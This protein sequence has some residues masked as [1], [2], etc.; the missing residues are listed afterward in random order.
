MED[1]GE[2]KDEKEKRGEDERGE[3]FP[4]SSR[5]LS[6]KPQADWVAGAHRVRNVSSH[7]NGKRRFPNV[8]WSVGEAVLQSFD[9]AS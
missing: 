3:R 1:E 5:P 9:S 6:T 2:K 4:P 7:D 8:V